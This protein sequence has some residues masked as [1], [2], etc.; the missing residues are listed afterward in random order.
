M[1]KLAH[2]NLVKFHIHRP[3][4]IKLFKV[5]Y[6]LK[7]EKCS[8]W[9]K[10]EQCSEVKI[11]TVMTKWVMNLPYVW[12]SRLMLGKQWYNSFKY[13]GTIMHNL[14]M[15]ELSLTQLYLKY[16]D[17]YTWEEGSTLFVN[18]YKRIHESQLEL[19]RYDTTMI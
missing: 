7:D 16:H 6:I 15:L 3:C 11:G 5:F 17:L 4:M 9:I 8:I 12:C 19:P 13:I 14:W 10:G 1:E 2:S 18:T